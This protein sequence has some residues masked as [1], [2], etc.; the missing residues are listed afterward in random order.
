[1]LSDDELTEHYTSLTQVFRRALEDIEWRLKEYLSGAPDDLQELYRAS[2][3]HS[4]IKPLESFLRKCRRES[5][6]DISTV[7]GRIED[8]LGVRIITASKPAA[9]SL[10]EHFQHGKTNWFCEL[11]GDPK[12]VPYTPED[13]N[14]YSLKSGYRAFHLTF[15]LRASYTPFTTIE[16]WP[17]EIQIMSRLW[18]FWADY[19]RRYFYL[20]DDTVAQQLLPYNVAISKILDT[21]DDLI[22]AN[23]EALSRVG[24]KVPPAPEEEVEAE[25][26][27]SDTAVTP[28][29]IRSWLTAN[30]AEHFG[31]AKMPNE[32]FLYKIAEELNL[33]GVSAEQ[34]SEIFDDTSVALRYWRI[35][36]A[37]DVKYLPPYQQILAKLLLFLGR[38]EETVVRHINS[39]L[40]PLPFALQSPGG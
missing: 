23:L 6:D 35:L 2:E 16:L 26:P 24:D 31:N 32:F 1:M 28:E 12:F 36:T 39:Q 15:V 19:S 40:G 8:L 13:N 22:T 18:Q 29:Q 33:Y 27:V 34:L 38:D 25:L 14:K 4:R 30:L 5:I 37:S 3:V 10:F 9:R 11:S 20:S 7:P 17:V 21:A